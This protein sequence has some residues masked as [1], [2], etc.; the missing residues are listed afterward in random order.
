MN[1]IDIIIGAIIIILLITI[2]A[3]QIAARKKPGSGE[4][5]ALL[6][7]A[8][9]EMRESVSRQIATGATEQFERFGMIN[10]SMQEA[11]LSNGKSVEA[12]LQASRAETNEQLSKSPSP[13]LTLCRLSSYA[14]T[15]SC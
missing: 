3:L 4:T 7:R 1:V 2:A 8:S 9:E 13:L 6:K 5:E 12:T 15:P 10:K 14:N 11:L